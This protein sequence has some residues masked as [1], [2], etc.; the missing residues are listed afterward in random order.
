MESKPLKKL[1]NPFY[2]EFLLPD[3]FGLVQST[4][5]DF[6]GEKYVY[7]PDGIAYFELKKLSTQRFFK[8]S[9]FRLIASRLLYLNTDIEFDFYVQ[10]MSYISKHHFD[11]PYSNKYIRS[12][13]DFFYEKKENGSLYVNAK[14]YLIFNPSSAFENGEKKE[15]EKQVLEAE[16]SKKIELAIN[17]LTKQGSKIT[18]QVI[19]DLINVSVRTINRH[20]SKYKKEIS[21]LNKKLREKHRNK[22]LTDTFLLLKSEGKATTYQALSDLTKFNNTEIK[23]FLDS[24]QKN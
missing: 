21:I 22:I 13:C 18:Q 20:I 16:M 6:K 10:V 12:C 8:S 9:Q 19:A 15:I 14:R 1:P 7:F 24:L 5:L 2:Y 4:E 23:L 3:E 17:V 11:A